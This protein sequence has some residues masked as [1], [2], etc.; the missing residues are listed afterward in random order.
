[1]GMAFIQSEQFDKASGRLEEIWEQD[2]SDLTV[3]EY[4]AVAY[5]NTEDRRALPRL[6]QQA[7]EIIGKL[8]ASRARVTF[9]VLHS[10]EKLAW[11]QGREMNQFCRGR[12]SIV[13]RHLIYVASKGEKASEHSFD[14]TP[15]AFKGIALH[16]DD[17]RGTFDLKL[18]QGN[19]FFAT[20]NRNRDE[21]IVIVDL[22]NRQ[23]GF[24]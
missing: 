19:F 14:V 12:L 10:H 21:A 23:L 15:T 1:M 3:G 8:A 7:F 22:A 9:L 2:Q 17:T 16:K 18:A 6:K 24:K 11:L 4:L 5:L 20:R 13:D